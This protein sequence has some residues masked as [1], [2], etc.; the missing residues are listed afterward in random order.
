M[1]STQSQ[2]SFGHCEGDEFWVG[3]QQ[4][5]QTPNT[6]AVS[7]AEALCDEQRRGQA[8]K[9]AVSSKVR[10]FRLMLPSYRL[11]LVGAIL[12]F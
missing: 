3:S 7:D 1:Q 5:L 10:I 11:F 2:S 9:D 6:E 12:F 8:T 4:S